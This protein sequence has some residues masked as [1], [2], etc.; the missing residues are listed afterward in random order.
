[1]NDKFDVII[2]G[3]GPA[4]LKCAEQFKNSGLSV[5]LI[6]KNKIIGPKTCAGGITSLGAIFDLPESKTRNFGKLTVCLSDKVHKVDL[7]N[8]IKT[9]DRYDL[10]QY[11]L[12]KIKDCKNIRVLKEI[13]VTHIKKDKVLTNRGDFCYKYL[14]G[15]D[16]SVSI[17][18]KYLGLKP[19][20]SVGLYYK[21]PEIVNDFV[22][23]FSPKSLG[24]EYIWIFPHR[25]YSNIG[26]FFE[27]R[28]LSSEKARKILEKF[29]ERNGFT[30]S[31]DRLEAAPINFSYQGCTFGNVFLIGDAAGLA[32]E[33]TGE[34]ISY[35]LVSGQEIGRKILNPDYK[36]EKLKKLLK[37]KKR[38]E[39]VKRVLSASGF[40]LSFRQSF[41]KCFAGL[42]KK[43]WFQKYLGI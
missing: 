20:V 21:V 35:A 1:M 29:L 22:L 9:I 23:Y 25:K 12:D 42:I 19:K 37:I 10:G 24:L 14:V 3:A 13:T 18:R 30:Y 39:R 15:A 36:M 32:S 26:V 16:G 40:S 11:L 17:V 4:G 43:P 27:P 33:M 5:L 6:E 31:R 2:V 34:G 38:Q 28:F 41:Y 8:P 7:V